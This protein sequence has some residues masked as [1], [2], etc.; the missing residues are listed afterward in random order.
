M[1]HNTIRNSIFLAAALAVSAFLALASAHAQTSHDPPRVKRPAYQIT[2][3]TGEKFYLVLD[4]GTIFDVFTAGKQIGTVDFRDPANSLNAT[5]APYAENKAALQRAYEARATQQPYDGPIPGLADAQQPTTQIKTSQ[6]SL[7]S[8]PQATYQNLKFKPTKMT[9]DIIVPSPPESRTI[10]VELNSHFGSGAADK[11][12]HAAAATGRNTLR[13]LTGHNKEIESMAGHDYVEIT[14]GKG[15]Q[16][17]NTNVYN[18]DGSPS[19]GSNQTFEI[20]LGRYKSVFLKIADDIGAQSK[21]QGAPA[22]EYLQTL[23]GIA[24]QKPPSAQPVQQ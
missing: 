14:M 9:V 12:G 8:A 16:K 11:A 6:G 10:Y 23:Y 13:V 15:L 2:T 5:A 24:G 17:S 1:S 20:V 18:R 19:G 22:P 21:A 7:F 3:P 4:Q